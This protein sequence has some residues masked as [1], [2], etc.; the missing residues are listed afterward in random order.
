MNYILNRVT[1]EISQF[2]LLRNE[3][4]M[5]SVLS[6][7]RLPRLWITGAKKKVF[8]SLKIDFFIAHA[9]PG[10]LIGSIKWSTKTTHRGPYSEVM[11]GHTSRKLKIWKAKFCSKPDFHFFFKMVVVSDSRFGPCC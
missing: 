4:I 3:H 7:I 11:G 2:N 8:F 1:S 10:P 6:W 9:M 5:K